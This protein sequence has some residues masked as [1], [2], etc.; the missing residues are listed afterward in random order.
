[1]EASQNKPLSMQSAFQSVV[2]KVHD[3][4]QAEGCHSMVSL[5]SVFCGAF[6]RVVPDQWQEVGRVVAATLKHSPSCCVE[7]ASFGVFPSKALASAFS[8]LKFKYFWTLARDIATGS[9]SVAKKDYSVTLNLLSAPEVM[10]EVL[11]VQDTLKA[12]EWA[13]FLHALFEPPE[14]FIVDGAFV[15]EKFDALIGKITIPPASSSSASTTTA[16]RQ[17]NKNRERVWTA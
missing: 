3:G 7:D 11:E 6:S 2:K 5:I 17:R 10:T 15:K 16:E 13:G 9:E 4:L 8:K 1:M 12:E 14:E